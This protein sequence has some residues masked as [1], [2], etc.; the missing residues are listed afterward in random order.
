MFPAA[1]RLKPSQGAKAGQSQVLDAA[2]Y[3]AEL[4]RPAQRLLQMTGQRMAR[5]SA[6]RAARLRPRC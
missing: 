1:L 5:S 6:R 4:E 3:C 2:A